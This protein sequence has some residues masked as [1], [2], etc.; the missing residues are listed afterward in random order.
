MKD[1]RCW[2]FPALL[3][4]AVKTPLRR[5]VVSGKPAFP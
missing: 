1:A 3:A 4:T 2:L 5:R